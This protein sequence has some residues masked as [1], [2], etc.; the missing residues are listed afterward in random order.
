MAKTLSVITE[1][2][3]TILECR[4]Q[5]ADLKHDKI[6]ARASA[7]ESASG[8]ADQKKDYVRSVVA[9]LDCEISKL[10]AKIEYCYNMMKMEQGD[11]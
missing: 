1:Y 6:I 5:I 7:W 2:T 9:N 4:N 10:E 3:E 11:E 8:I